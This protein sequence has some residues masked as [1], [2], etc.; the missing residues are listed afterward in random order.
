MP[1]VYEWMGARPG[2]IVYR[3]PDD[4]IVWGS[5]II[6]KQNQAAIL[7]KEGKAYDVLG[8]GRHFITTK[9]LPLITKF[10]SRIVGYDRSPF[11]AEVIFVSTSDFKG[12]FGGR[13]QTTDLAPLQF[14]GEYYWEVKD[15]SAFVMEI[16]GNQKIYNSQAAS[17]YLRGF[18]IQTSIDQLSHYPLVKVMRE[19]DEVSEEIE[20]NIVPQLMRW[21]INLIDLKYLGV[22]TTQE[23]RDRLFW[24]QSGVSADK[25]ITLKTV[26]KSTEHLGKSPG[27]GFGAGMV[28]LPELMRQA[29]QTRSRGTADK[30][31]IITCPNCGAHTSPAAKFCPNCGTQMG[32]SPKK[33][34]KFCPNCGD[35]ID[36]GEKFC[37]ACGMKLV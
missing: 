4:R 6:V 5:Q 12:K 16:V 35:K 25:L 18:F 34:Q 3:H 22:D 37:S 23:Y 7:F 24:M 26:E 30:E 19:L 14:H 2:D 10:L 15:P 31:A 17:E 27:A 11:N 33:A 1:E 9:N 36:P 21:G 28:L 20:K 32:V 13:S 8:P 29:E